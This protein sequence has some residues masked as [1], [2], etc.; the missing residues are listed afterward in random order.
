MNYKGK[1]WQSEPSHPPCCDSPSL[2]KE[3]EVRSG[4]LPLSPQCCLS[5][6]CCLVSTFSTWAGDKSAIDSQDEREPAG[7]FDISTYPSPSKTRHVHAESES[8]QH[9]RAGTLWNSCCIFSTDHIFSYIFSCNIPPTSRCS[10][11]HW[12]YTHVQFP[13]LLLY[14]QIHPAW[15][16]PP[17]F[18]RGFGQKETL[19]LL[20]RVVRELLLS[21]VTRW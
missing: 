5:G 1:E 2:I 11:R 20:A 8:N 12:V 16:Y 10:K 6:N 15:F 9:R 19:P 4:F 13:S 17:V 18:D 7:D 3:S 14:W 21:W